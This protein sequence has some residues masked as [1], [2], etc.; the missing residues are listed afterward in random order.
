[1]EQQAE[2]VSL[3][4]L[5]RGGFAPDCEVGLLYEVLRKNRAECRCG[6]GHVTPPPNRYG[7]VALL[8][9]GLYDIS[10]NLVI[11]SEMEHLGAKEHPLRCEVKNDSVLDAQLLQTHFNILRGDIALDNGAGIRPDGSIIPYGHMPPQSDIVL[12]SW[13]RVDTNGH[14]VVTAEVAVFDALLGRGNH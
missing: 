11:I 4:G 13:L 9:R 12:R 8:A 1:M 7:T 6:P 3:D 10:C 14:A 5:M 2:L